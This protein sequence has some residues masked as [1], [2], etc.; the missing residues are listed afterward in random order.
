MGTVETEP[1]TETIPSPLLEG[2]PTQKAKFVQITS[3]G[4]TLF[5]LDEDGDVWGNHRGTS[6]WMRLSRIKVGT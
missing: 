5:A 3:D 4:Q 1:V 2:V 6:V